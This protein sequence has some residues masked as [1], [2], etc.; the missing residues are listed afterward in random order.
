MRWIDIKDFEGLYQISDTGLVKSCERNIDNPH[1][2][3]QK[4]KEKILKP[5]VMKDGYL[6]ITLSK[7]AKQYKYPIHIL[8]AQA[9]VENPNKFEIVNHIDENKANNN[10]T[11]LEWCHCQY[12][13]E[14]SISRHYIAIDPLGTKH[15][16]FNLSDFCR[17]HNL[18]LSAMS[19][20]ATGRIP[21]NKRSPRLS[22]KG[23][24]CSYLHNKPLRGVMKHDC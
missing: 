3:M 22:H 19:E 1:T 15:D 4:K 17:I 7:N 13:L 6:R 21:K 10:Y 9:F 12:N 5:D 24:K 2:G 16:V 14:Y 11:N 18:S 8:V 23:W 20:M